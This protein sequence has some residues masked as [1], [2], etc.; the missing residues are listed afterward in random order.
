MRITMNTHNNT[1]NLADLN[2][3][4]TRIMDEILKD[5]IQ[6]GTQYQGYVQNI[7]KNI[8]VMHEQK[9]IKVALVGQYSSG[10]STIISALTNNRQIK[11]SGSIKSC[12][13]HFIS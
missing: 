10:K 13:I 2:E 4:F 8:T 6:A 11:I 3:N 1:F 12:V 5:L 9:L 7:E